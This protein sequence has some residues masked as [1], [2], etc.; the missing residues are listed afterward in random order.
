[1]SDVVKDL[2][3]KVKEQKKDIERKT[4]SIEEFAEIM[5]IGRDAA[6]QMCRSSN[7]PPYIKIGNRYRI[8]SSR[9]DQ[10]IDSIIGQE[11]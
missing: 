7:P 4:L 11:F 9:L 6:R 1:M 3:E 8:I 10:W 5:D 2:T